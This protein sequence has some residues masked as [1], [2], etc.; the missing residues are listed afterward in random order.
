MFIELGGKTRQIRFNYNAL[1]DLEQISGASIQKLFSDSNNLGFN[2]IRMLVWAG[3]KAADPGLTIQRTGVLI[4]QSVSA[5]TPL[6]DIAKVFMEEL[7][8][9]SAFG[10][11]STDEGDNEKNL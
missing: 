9:S 11:Q 4:E 2:F 3:L 8:K 6:G 1:A 10:K 5:G 7:S